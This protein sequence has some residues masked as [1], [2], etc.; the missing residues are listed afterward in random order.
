[1]LKRGG[2]LHANQVEA[3]VY[4]GGRLFKQAKESLPY[5]MLTFNQS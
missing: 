3:I 5:R 1:M 2:S 4:N